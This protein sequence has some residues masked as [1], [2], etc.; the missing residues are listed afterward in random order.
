V[1]K[2]GLPARN[3]DN[4]FDE[5]LGWL[6]SFF[7][8]TVDKVQLGFETPLFLKIRHQQWV[9]QPRTNIEQNLTKPRRKQQS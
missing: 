4:N 1:K 9:P 6:A 3:K 8:V 2:R 5:G 7:S